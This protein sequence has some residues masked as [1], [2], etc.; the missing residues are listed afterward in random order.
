MS[1]GERRATIEAAAA[2]LFA[3]R[4]YVEASIDEIAAR[5][6]VSPPV[7]YDHFESKVELYRRV[8]ELHYAGLR[9]VWHENFGGEEPAGERLSRSLDAWFAFVEKH[10]FAGRMLFRDS[11]GD[12]RADASQAEVAGASRE[13]LMPLLSGESLGGLTDREE[14]EMTWVALRGVLQG[15]A[16]WWAGHPELPRERL[17]A[18][19]MNLI[20][21]G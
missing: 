12:A 21:I 17:V 14:L 4:G 16:V 11:V 13:A 5:S 6:G 7:V 15:L 8:V 20:R 3:E 9:G 19:A 1:G 10:P 18:T 2:G